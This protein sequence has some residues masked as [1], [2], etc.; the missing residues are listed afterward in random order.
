MNSLRNVFDTFYDTT[1]PLIFRATQKDPELAHSLFSF[2]SQSLYKT[3]IDKLVLDNSTNYNENQPLIPISCAAGLNKNAQIPPTFLKYLGF[4]RIVVGTLTADYFEGNKRP[5]VK[6]YPETE[7]L[8]N[9]MGLPGI[10]SK[11]ISER[12]KRY[13][14]HNVPLTINLMAT[15]GRKDKEALEA[16]STTIQQTRDIPYVD[17][18]ELN[19]SCPNT[20]SLEGKLD[21]RKENARQAKQMIELILSQKRNSQELYLK[22]SP[23]LDKESIDIIYEETS[24]LLNGYTTTNTTTDYNSKFLDPIPEKGGASGNALYDLSLSMQKEFQRRIKESGNQDKLKIIACGGI[25][26]R[27][28]LLSRFASGASE[29]QIYTGFI[30]KGPRL[31][32]ELRQK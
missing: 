17:R 14:E 3:G 29:A 15:P 16:I 24:P 1:K 23:D 4:D 2:F 26:S 18:F 31:L 5:R 20:H 21:A 7:S 8:V 11:K 12:L 9:W 13:G 19:V 28:R 25:N 22:V 10:G 30:F 27:F 32:R 6:R